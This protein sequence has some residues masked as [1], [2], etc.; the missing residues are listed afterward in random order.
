MRKFLLASLIVMFLTSPVMAT[1]P[2]TY[3]TL[4]AGVG[5]T[6]TLDHVYWVSVYARTNEMFVTTYTKV[7][8]VQT[9]VDIMS[10]PAGVSKTF[11]AIGLSQMVLGS[12]LGTI[13]DYNLSTFKEAA[14]MI[15]PS[16]SDMAADIDSLLIRASQP[17]PV[18]VW[19]GAL[20]TADIV[21]SD[22]VL[23]GP[24]TGLYVE[25]AKSFMVACSYDSLD[26]RSN[27]KFTVKQ[28]FVSAAG[29]TTSK[30]ADGAVA[31]A[32][33]ILVDGAVFGK[34]MGSL[35]WFPEIPNGQQR[36]TGYYYCTVDSWGVVTIRDLQISA[37]VVF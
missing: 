3:V 29:D 10:V 28:W 22:V 5:Q 36:F 19:T 26:G 13:V 14:P 12:T 37:R 31:L 2:N 18:D 7:A 30:T 21:R 34:A 8:G 6:I 16:T 27:D 32:D 4:A 25:G 17:E 11:L 9:V 20:L 1:G 15:F 35:T 33:T 24:Q 23:S